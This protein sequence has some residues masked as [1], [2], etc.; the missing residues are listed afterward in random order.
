MKLTMTSGEVGKRIA[1]CKQCSNL[2]KMNFCKLCGCFMPAKVRIPQA[3]CP[4]LKWDSASK[5]SVEVIPTTQVDE[6]E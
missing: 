2:N 6:N 3:A 5:T 1:L 4:I